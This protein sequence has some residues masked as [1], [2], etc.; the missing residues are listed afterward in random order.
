[1][2]GRFDFVELILFS[3]TDEKLSKTQV[4]CNPSLLE[5][6]ASDQSFHPL[7]HLLLITVIGRVY[8]PHVIVKKLRGF[9]YLRSLSQ[10][11]LSWAHLE[12]RSPGS[13]LF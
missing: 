2:K 7:S 3:F 8:N 13:L 1:M 4:E 6:I 5:F 10:Q 12:H 9:N 11:I